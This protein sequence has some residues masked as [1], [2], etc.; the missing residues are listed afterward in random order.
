[1]NNTLESFCA[2]NGI[3]LECSVAHTPE[4]NGVAERANRKV[5][6]KLCT[7]MKDAAAPDFLWADAGA[8]ATYA[9]NRTISVSSGGVTPFEAFFGMRPLIDHMHIW[10]CNVFIHRDKALG[11]KKLGE[12]GKLVKFL[13]YPENV[14]GYRT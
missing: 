12:R 10:Y 11:A 1:M 5:E 14:S 8:I 7:L 6:D 4:Q 3:I 2:N 13:G 9:I